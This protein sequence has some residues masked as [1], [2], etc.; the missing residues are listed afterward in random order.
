MKKYYTFITCLCI[1]AISFIVG[2]ENVNPPD[3]RHLKELKKISGVH[4]FQNKPFTGIA[5]GSS[6]NGHAVS[7]VYANGKLNG[8]VKFWTRNGQL[9]SNTGMKGDL[10]HGIT[11]SYSEDGAIIGFER[12]K[13]GEQDGYSYILMSDDKIYKQLYKDGELKGESIIPSFP[14]F[15]QN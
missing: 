6:K 12:F 5:I 10:L 4:Y 8:A 3:V 14:K 9:S 7:M 1:T 2:K 15:K 13:N 11:T